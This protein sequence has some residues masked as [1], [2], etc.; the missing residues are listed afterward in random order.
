MDWRYG[1]SG[2]ERIM[3]TIVEYNQGIGFARCA[4]FSDHVLIRDS[5]VFS[6]CGQYYIP[7]DGV[8][9]HL[10]SGDLIETLV[11]ETQVRL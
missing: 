10:L 4:N 8:A 5:E 7:L 9:S 3:G 11:I 6:I 2:Q 1:L